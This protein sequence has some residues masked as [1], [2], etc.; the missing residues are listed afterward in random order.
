MS[1]PPDN[2]LIIC[3]DIQIYK[4]PWLTRN[5]E[6]FLLFSQSIPSQN[7]GFVDQTAATLELSIG[8]RDL[9]IHQSPTVL[10]S[11]RSG[12]TTGAGKCRS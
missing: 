4:R 5:P 10:A 11:Q 6:A 12:G 9:S 3:I 7:L 1:D 8:D 2:K